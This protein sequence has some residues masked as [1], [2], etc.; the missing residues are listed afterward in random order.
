MTSLNSAWFRK[1]ML[2]NPAM[3]D[4]PLPSNRNLSNEMLSWLEFPWLLTQMSQ[5]LQEPRGAGER[6]IVLP[7][8]GAGDLSTIPLRQYLT[9][10]GYSVKGWSNGTNNGDVEKLLDQMRSRVALQ[11]RHLE[12]PVC[13]IGWSLG[14]Y[15]AREVARDIPEHVSSVITMGSPVVGGPKYTRVAPVFAQRGMSLD[16]IEQQV[17]ERYGTPL[18]VPVTAIY[19]QNDGVVAWEACIDEFS[20]TVTHVEV[21]TSHIGLGFSADVYR[22]VARALAGQSVD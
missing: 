19:S 14:G 6:V 21:S 18:K 20:T 4:F 13:L 8:F 2:P 12:A 17:D 1:E 16:E 7:G 9:T 3:R 10:M 5:L 22:I 15:I 11:S